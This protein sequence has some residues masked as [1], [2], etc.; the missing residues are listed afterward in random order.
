MVVNFITY[1]INWVA[2]KLVWKL[3]LIKKIWILLKEAINQPTKLKSDLYCI[4]TSQL[5][6][7]QFKKGLLWKVLVLSLWLYFEHLLKPPLKPVI[8][9]R[10]KDSL[11]CSHPALRSRHSQG[12][13]IKHLWLDGAS[14]MSLLKC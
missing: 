5:I 3:L 2:Q 13:Q 7:I 1:K 11:A 4:N 14:S 12:G 8:A 10:V 6:E 9:D